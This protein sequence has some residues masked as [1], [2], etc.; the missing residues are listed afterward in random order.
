MIIQEKGYLKRVE[1]SK[2]GIK[3]LEEKQIELKKLK[4]EIEQL[5]PLKLNAE[6]KKNEA[7][8]N[9]REAKEKHENAWK[10]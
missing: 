3:F 7:E 4:S 9:E 2:N 10:S 1:L 8:K 6:V 5:E